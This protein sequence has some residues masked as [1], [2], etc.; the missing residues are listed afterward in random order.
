MNGAAIAVSSAAKDMA[1]ENAGLSS[2][3]E[4]LK[5]LAGSIAESALEVARRAAEVGRAM[6]SVS[7]LADRTR[8]SIIRNE[9][10]IGAF[11]VS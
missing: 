11:K 5:R 6:D 9:E 1:R 2:A 8:K 4:S 7:A 10:A 3:F